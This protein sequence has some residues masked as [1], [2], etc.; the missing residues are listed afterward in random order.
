[1]A[2]ILFFIK[3]KEI[4]PIKKRICKLL[5]IL[6]ILKLKLYFQ[7]SINLLNIL[8]KYSICLKCVNIQILITIRKY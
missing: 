5:Y 2:S 1:M 3:L 4:S 6:F 8:S 7:F